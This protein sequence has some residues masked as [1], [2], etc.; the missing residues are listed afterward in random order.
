MTIRLRDVWA[1][2][3]L[4]DFKVHFAR[5][6]GYVEPLDVFARDRDEWSE[7]QEYRSRRDR[8]N[9]EFV[10]S[11]A[12]FYHETDI[13]LF[14]G[15][16][17]VL[18]RHADSYVVRLT[19]HGAGFLGRMKLR[20]P[21]RAM[22]S[23][24]RLEGQYDRF[25]VQEILRE[26]YTGRA[27]PG[28]ENIDL[29]FSELETLIRNER[30]DWRI[31]MQNVAGIYLISIHTARA[32]RRYVGAA[33][34]DQGVWSRWL[35]YIETGHGGTAELSKLVG[36]RGRDFCRQHFRFALLEHLA[37]NTPNETVRARED[38]W[39][40]MLGTRAPGGLNRN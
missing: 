30:P 2:E 3:N 19:E 5:W 29:S 22:N 9:R 28:L 6:N 14:G 39:K 15:V 40:R 32:V 8:F 17:Q 35:N 4:R 13:W 25:E 38:R 18:E 12:R 34:G 37:L 23:S 10:F 27:F 7:W 26:P 24:V 31:P 36:K 1:I 20:T 16:F 33:Y 11:L 21:F